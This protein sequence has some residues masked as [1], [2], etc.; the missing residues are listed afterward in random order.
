M[1]DVDPNSHPDR[2][3][4]SD[5]FQ[6]LG[7]LTRYLQAPDHHV[8]EELLQQLVDACD[9]VARYYGNE[10]CDLPPAWLMALRGLFDAFLAKAKQ[11]RVVSTGLH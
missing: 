7:T 6:M 4:F 1:T 2:Q 10:H 11:N 9:D 8:D 5:L 3:T